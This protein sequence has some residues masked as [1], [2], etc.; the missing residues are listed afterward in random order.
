MVCEL[1]N[2]TINGL[3]YYSITMLKVDEEI[4]CLAGFVEEDLYGLQLLQ[5][6]ITTRKTF[7]VL[8]SCC[9]ACLLFLSF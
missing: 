8:V 3:L 2:T 5:T 9:F 1:I 7:F 4:T 6:F